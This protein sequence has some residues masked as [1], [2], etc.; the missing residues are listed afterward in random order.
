[1]MDSSI[2]LTTNGNLRALNSA[3][4]T[5][6][7]TSIDAPAITMSKNN[8]LLTVEVASGLVAGNATSLAANNDATAFILFEN[9]L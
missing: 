5:E 4:G 1:M 8:V 9:R 6:A 7:V 2:T 3:G